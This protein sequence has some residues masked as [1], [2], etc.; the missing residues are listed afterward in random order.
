MIA[1]VALIVAVV[2][3]ASANA[4]L[5]TGARTLTL[6]LSSETFFNAL[7]N[8]YLVGGIALFALNVLCYIYALSKL[9]LSL[10]YPVMVV[11]GLLIVISTSVL[12]FGESLS[13]VQV[14]GLSLVV[15][16]VILFY[17]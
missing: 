17:L 12:I 7:T 13:Y 6:P 1:W 4:L 15:L 9:P 8:L 16:G 11:G 2:M 10:A 5:K 3:N 14:G